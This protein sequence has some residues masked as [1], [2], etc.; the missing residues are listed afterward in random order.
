MYLIGSSIIDTCLGHLP[1]I[2]NFANFDTA[3]ATEKIAPL[4]FTG[5]LTF[6]TKKDTECCSF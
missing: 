6:Y 4:P 1:Y 3:A 2:H 5:T